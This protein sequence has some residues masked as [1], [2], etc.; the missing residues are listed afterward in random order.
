[1][2]I[3]TAI[4]VQT[5][6]HYQDFNLIGAQRKRTSPSD[7]IS[8][9]TA[10]ELRRLSVIVLQGTDTDTSGSDRNQWPTNRS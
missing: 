1:M 2:F 8:T 3:V 4:L 9:I 5:V 7:T 10:K 6:S